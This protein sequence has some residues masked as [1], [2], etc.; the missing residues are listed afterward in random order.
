MDPFPVMLNPLPVHPVDLEE[1][2]APSRGSGEETTNSA[3]VSAVKTGFKHIPPDT[4]ND[5]TLSPNERLSLTCILPEELIS[6]EGELSGTETDKPKKNEEMRYRETVCY[7]RAFIS[8]NYIPDFELEYS[9][10]DK[11]SSL[12]RS[13]NPGPSKIY[14]EMTG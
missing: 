12:W 14:V 13:K 5:L 3:G 8:R 10:P 11:S 7:I 9:D 2:F 1:Q 4:D 6:E